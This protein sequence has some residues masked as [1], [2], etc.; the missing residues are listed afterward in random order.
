MLKADLAELYR[1]SKSLALYACLPE[2]YE[3]AYVSSKVYGENNALRWVITAVR[4]GN[5]RLAFIALLVKSALFKIKILVNRADYGKSVLTSL[6]FVSVRVK[7][8]HRVHCF[9]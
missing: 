6:L 8:V 2:L 1:L 4:N 7:G 3:R 5:A 9:S